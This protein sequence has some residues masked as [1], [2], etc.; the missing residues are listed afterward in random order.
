[1]NQTALP[2]DG[3]CSGPLFAPLQTRRAP[4]PR[5]QS[6]YRD[7]VVRTRQPDWADRSA[8]RAIYQARDEMASSTGEP[9]SVDHIV[10]LNHP[11]VCGLHV[12][13]NLQLLPLAENIRKGNNW[14]PDMWGEQVEIFTCLA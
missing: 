5:M 13:N 14:W 6:T 9:Y 3:L 11:L 10:P 12:Q 1:M 4:K 2:L 8:I 7:Q